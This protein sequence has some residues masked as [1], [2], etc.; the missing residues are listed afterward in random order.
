MR[1]W[2]YQSQEKIIID[3]L[4]WCI[5]WRFYLKTKTILQ[6]L[7]LVS[8]CLI[9]IS[10]HELLALANVVLPYTC[11]LTRSLHDTA[12]KSQSNLR[13]LRK[14]LIFSCAICRTH[15]RTSCTPKQTAYLQAEGFIDV[16]KSHLFKIRACHYDHTTFGN[17]SQYFVS[18]AITCA[19]QTVLKIFPFPLS[20][21]DSHPLCDS[22]LGLVRNR[23]FSWIRL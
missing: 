11:P 7:I 18:L 6:A 10:C 17:F 20:I 1:F 12:K 5:T 16:C 22:R 2:W 4:F 9:K 3:I 14:H 23:T 13:F 19:I 21:S 8:K 15:V